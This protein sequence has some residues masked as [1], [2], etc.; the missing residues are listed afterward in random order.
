MSLCLCVFVSFLSFL[1]FSLCV[2]LCLF[3][4]A[5]LCLCVFIVFL[6]FWS[7]WSFWSFFVFFYHVNQM[8]EGSQVSKVT[9]CVKI[10]MSEWVTKVRY[11]A[12]R[13][14]KNTLWT[15]G[16]GVETHFQDLCFSPVVHPIVHSM[17]EENGSSIVQQE[18]RK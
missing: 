7:F 4:F 3:V 9:L 2:F 10:Q 17:L 18:E 11:R 13:A 14:A 16:F 12:A 8:C 15:F 6:S 1:S 5:S